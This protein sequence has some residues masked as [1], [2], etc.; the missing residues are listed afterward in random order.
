MY[1]VTDVWLTG[2]QK[3]DMTGAL[4]PNP[5]ASL[6]TTCDDVTSYLRRNGDVKH[7]PYDI[8]MD[9]FSIN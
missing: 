2:Y 1:N 7:F 9:E 5:D 8:V 6:E 3:C 4:R